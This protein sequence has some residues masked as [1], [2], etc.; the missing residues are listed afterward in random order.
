MRAAGTGEEPEVDL[1]HA[2]LRLRR[3]Q[4]DV[5]GQHQLRT[6]AEGEAVDGSDGRLVQDLDPAEQ[7]VNVL[8]ELLVMGEALARVEIGDIAAGDE[9]AAR[10][11][12]QH[13]PHRL[14]RLDLAYRIVEG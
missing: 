1:G 7:P 5:G 6:A 2:D 13:D 11:G 9:R 14:V 4:P 3:Q 12:E 8:G 10:A